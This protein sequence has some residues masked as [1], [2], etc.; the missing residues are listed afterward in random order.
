MQESKGG[1]T[2]YMADGEG[3]LFC[4]ES[5]DSDLRQII[6]KKSKTFQQF[7]RAV[8]SCRCQEKISIRLHHH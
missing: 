1:V 8:F 7:L 3:F 5:V 4:C 6:P 2:D